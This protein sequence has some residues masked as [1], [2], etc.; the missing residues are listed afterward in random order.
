M[1][2]LAHAEY[3]V[4]AFMRETMRVHAETIQRVEQGLPIRENP[5]LIIGLVL[6]GYQTSRSGSRILVEAA[7]EILKA[8]KLRGKVTIETALKKLD[9]ALKDELECLRGGGDFSVCRALNSARKK[10]RSLKKFSGVFVFPAIISSG[11]S[12]VD[13]QIGPVRLLDRN[14]FLEL[15]GHLF[16]K[17]ADDS[18]R[19]KL[20]SA[21]RDRY[22]NLQY[23]MLVNVDDHE[24]ELGAVAARKAANHF[25]NLIRLFVGTDMA[26]RIRIIDEPSINHVG[27]EL[28]ITS[29]GEAQGVVTF[30][31][32][33]AVLPDDWV[34]QLRFELGPVLP[35]IEIILKKYVRGDDK[36]SPS[37]E[38]IEY[39]DHLVAEA[40]RDGDLRM[41][42][43]KWIAAIEALCVLGQSE[44]ARNIS[45]RCGLVLWRGVPSVF[46]KDCSVVRTAYAARNAIVH[47]DAIPMKAVS[48]AARELDGMIYILYLYLLREV[49][50]AQMESNPQS[51][52]ALRRAL[53]DRYRRV[54][55]HVVCAGGLYVA[56]GERY[57]DFDYQG[58]Y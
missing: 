37:F 7:T 44:K 19:S 40:Y 2:R 10:L 14:K 43:V 21:W 35:M 51:I 15:Y 56:G 25:L 22:E 5:D 33:G 17:G 12:S 31:G 36:D 24:Y 16:E 29:A 48:K 1:K 38:R 42:L 6:G 49:V 30:G 13:F 9:E 47:G 58:M 54:V 52:K 27:A 18:F 20:T 26:D 46:H 3:L 55:Y 53:N 39:A 32:V 50:F 11:M 23:F 34:D 8:E 28:A 45:F 41:K 4:E 57:A